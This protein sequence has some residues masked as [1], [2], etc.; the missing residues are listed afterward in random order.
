[1]KQ[2]P[3]MNKDLYDMVQNSVSDADKRRYEKIGKEMYGSVDYDKS[4]ILNN[5][6]LLLES[7]TYIMEAL[8]SGLHYSDLSDIEIAVMK[9]SYGDNWID[10]LDLGEK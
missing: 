10:V 6:D 3:R 7:T 4:K 9:E 5:P 1:M 8:K 2:Q